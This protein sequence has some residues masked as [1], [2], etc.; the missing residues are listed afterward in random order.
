[1]LPVDV[2]T[3]TVVKKGFF[4]GLEFDFLYLRYEWDD[5]NG[6]KSGDSDILQLM[7]Y[8][9]AG[10]S[11][12]FDPWVFDIIVSGGY[13]L[14]VTLSGDDVGTDFIYAGGLGLGYRF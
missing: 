8:A 4:A 14:N 6:Q 1:M 3:R 5:N 11:I 13:P 10:Y 9:Q 2:G 12:D 7:S